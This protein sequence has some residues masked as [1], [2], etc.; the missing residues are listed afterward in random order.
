[1]D[2][3]A[4]G[5][6]RLAAGRT[7]EHGAR[8]VKRQAV[9]AEKAE[10]MGAATKVVAGDDDEVM[11]LVGTTM[12]KVG[13]APGTEEEEEERQRRERARKAA[14]LACIADD[15]EEEEEGDDK[16]GAGGE[17]MEEED[18]PLAGEDIYGIDP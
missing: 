9:G 15:D 3:L 5:L 17:K 14:F 13:L 2:G 8:G 16:K 11:E 12:G 4:A 7:S 10:M 6:T 18:D 1:M